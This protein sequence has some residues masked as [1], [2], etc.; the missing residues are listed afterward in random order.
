MANYDTI[1][2][3]SLN[4]SLQPKRKIN[5][6]TKD[7]SKEIWDIFLAKNAPRSKKIEAKNQKLNEFSSNIE[8]ASENMKVKFAL[9][10]DH[11]AKNNLLNPES[12]K[13]LKI[14]WKDSDEKLQNIIEDL[15]TN[16]KT[17]LTEKQKTELAQAV[18]DWIEKHYLDL[19]EKENN[20]EELK[21]KNEE[22]EDELNASE[23][24]NEVV[25]SAILSKRSI[26]NTIRVWKAIENINNSNLDPV[27]K[28]RKVLWQA[29]TFV[30][31]GHWKRREIFK[32][33]RGKFDVNKKYTEAVKNLKDKMNNAKEPK[34]KVA[35]RY[36][37]RQVNTAYK[38]YIDATNISE[39]TRKQ[40]M[41]DINQKM[42]A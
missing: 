10:I 12:I 17:P 19:A 41:K 40:N 42:A 11:L 4:K 32:K 3:S 8:N 7:I 35:I 22:L 30:L 29:D 38:T 28:A 15:T 1:D 6:I 36:I 33:L 39:E 26:N 27:A 9:T 37:M 34:E 18:A 31:F 13:S 2:Y 5:S 16:R 24:A 14:R 25:E 20:N 21:S 23:A